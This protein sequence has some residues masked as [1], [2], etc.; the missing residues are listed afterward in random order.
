MVDAPQSFVFA[1][2]A[3]PRLIGDIETL[4]DHLSREPNARLDLY[5]D[6]T[7]PDASRPGSVQ[8]QCLVGAT[9]PVASKAEFLSRIVRIQEGRPAPDGAQVDDTTFLIL[10]RD[11][12]SAV[13]SPVTVDSARVTRGYLHRSGPESSPKRRTD[14]YGRSIAR[15]GWFRWTLA[16]VLVAVTLMSY[17]Y[18]LAGQRLIA[19]RKQLES[20]FSTLAGDMERQEQKERIEAEARMRQGGMAG[21]AGQVVAVPAA[22]RDVAAWC[23]LV[24]WVPGL[25]P[26]MHASAEQRTLCRRY[27]G[28]MANYL[29]L[30]E[31]MQAWLDA[32]ASPFRILERT[33]WLG[34]V[35]LSDVN[36]AALEAAKGKGQTMPP[37]VWPLTC[38][39]TLDSVAGLAEP[40]RPLQVASVTDIA[41]P[42]APRPEE[43]RRLEEA[44][45]LTEISERYWLRFQ[46]GRS[47][48]GGVETMVKIVSDYLLPCLFAMIGAV[49]AGLRTLTV[50]ASTHRLTFGDGSTFWHTALFGL[51]LGAVIG[52]F[53]DQFRGLDDGASLAPGLVALLVGFSTPLVFGALDRLSEKIFGAI[54]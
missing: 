49:A 10:A 46:E 52:L 18:V 2:D 9:P 42:D 22:T 50:R 44:R 29:K 28:V 51:L 7:R 6:D 24:G 32:A 48:N 4:L 26:P 34:L 35:G 5:F 33:W 15:Q 17:V 23:E 12:L 16:V 13:A 19:E 47:L 11:F 38:V 30:H 54:Q 27:Q 21:G 1:P 8:P 36:C 25:Q 20:F 14:I 41:A 53:V 37:A 31:Q 39:A 40:V 43:I 45:L 3:R